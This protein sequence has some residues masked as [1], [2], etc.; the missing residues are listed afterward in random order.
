MKKIILTSLAIICGIALVL[1]WREAG[2][3][4]GP[5]VSSGDPAGPTREVALVSNAV[6]GTVSVVDLESFQVLKT[7]NVIPDGPKVSLLRDPMQWYAQDMIEGRGG[8]NYAQDTDLSKDGTVMFVS[9]GFLGDVIAMDISSGDILWRTPIA[10]I[11][12]DHMDI[13]PNGKRLY[14]AALIQSGNIVEVLDTESGNKVGSFKTGH[15]PHDIHVTP[16]GAEIYVASLGDMQVDVANRGN[17]PEAYTITVADGD[18][19]EVLKEYR[20]DSGV[21]PFQLTEDGGTIYAQ[22]SN[23]HAIVARDLRSDT[24]TAR[25]DLPVADGVTEGDWDFEAPHHG[26][27]LTPDEKTLCAAG[28]AS[29]YAGIVNAEDLSLV[30]TV[31]VG[32]APSWAEVS[33]DGRLCIL[34]NNR[35]DDVSIVD[36]QQQTEIARIP[37]GRGPKHVTVGFLPTSVLISLREVK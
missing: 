35:S 18:T 16:D 8:L 5:R 6:G 22:L 29:D 28:R 32:D 37:V 24:T 4:T 13:S 7:L 27:A 10:G 19:L 25:I 21:R 3:G 31:P 14:V 30:A 12:S 1:S 2:H 20:F 36:L 26:L 15:W 23:T 33:G 17:S 9:R 11:R 34:P